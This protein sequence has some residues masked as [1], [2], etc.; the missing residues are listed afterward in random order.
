MHDLQSMDPSLETVF[1]PNNTPP[2]PLPRSV[3]FPSTFQSVSPSLCPS[4]PRNACCAQS[5]LFC[6]RLPSP[7]TRL[8]RPAVRT[9]ASTAST[10]S[11]PRPA[12]PTRSTAT[13]TRRFAH[14]RARAPTHRHK[15]REEENRAC[16]SGATAPSQ[17]RPH[18]RCAPRRPDGEHGIMLRSDSDSDSDSDTM[19]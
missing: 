17:A 7:P 19:T 5:I 14:M 3:L 13:S 6:N 4:I 15:P 16:S 10:C 18:R 1:V 2:P 9:R 12:A 8:A 11:S